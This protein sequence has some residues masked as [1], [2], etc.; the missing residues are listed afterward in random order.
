MRETIFV[1]I[2]NQKG[3][4]GKSCFTILLASHLYYGL[5]YRVGIMDCD[6]PQH[7]VAAFRKWESEEVGRNPYY[8]GLVEEQF[9]RLG[10]PVYPVIKARP[11]TAMDMA[12]KLLSGS[13]SG[14][15]ILLFD[16]PGTVNNVGVLDVLDNM[17]HYIIPIEGSLTV[18]ESSLNFACALNDPS[19]GDGRSGRVHLFWNKIDRRERNPLYGIYER[20]VIAPLGLSVMRSSFPLS[21]RFRKVMDGESRLIMISTLF[22]AMRQS[23]RGTDIDIGSFVSEICSI[24]KIG[25]NGSVDER[26][27]QGAVPCEIQDNGPEDIGADIDGD[28]EPAPPAMHGG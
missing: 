23:V 10:V 13:K 16:L 7:S 24:I 4:T 12:R 27:V 11:E 20:E 5:G 6:Y 18:L 14:Y 3:G 25:D 2:C 26:A 15:D 1:S 9:T 28:K 17:D 21:S 19:R 22:P 8:N